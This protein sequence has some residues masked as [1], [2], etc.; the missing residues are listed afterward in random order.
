MIEKGSQFPDA[1]LFESVEFTDAC[2][3]P[4]QP[5]KVAEALAGKRV[6]IF[7][8]PGAFT[9]TCS[10]KHLPGYRD[11][12]EALKSKGVDEIWCVSVNDGA[13]MAAW[14]REQ[15]VGG[16]VRLLG[17][18]SAELTRKLGLD[19]E[20]PGMGTRMARC[21]MLVNDGVLEGIWVEEPRKFEVSSAE[22]M[23]ERL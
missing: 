9:W 7:G 19:I 18:G 11:Q 5:V 1:T 13:V 3:M 14:G 23:L 12:Y 22:A 21:S 15:N 6:V 10:H 17:D 16:K 2:P 8:L 20:I 4:P